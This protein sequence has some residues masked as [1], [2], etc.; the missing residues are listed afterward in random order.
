[1]QGSAGALARPYVEMYPAPLPAHAPAPLSVEGELRRDSGAGAVAVAPS[2]GAR[3]SFLLP[4]Q[5]QLAGQH[6]QYQQ[7]RYIS[8]YRP[9]SAGAY[10]VSS[11]AHSAGAV[12][13]PASVAGRF[14]ALAPP[15]A[16]ATA[17]AAAAVVQPVP[18]PGGSYCHRSRD[19]HTL[20]ACGLPLPGSAQLSAA[21]AVAGGAASAP[22]ARSAA[23]GYRVGQADFSGGAPCFD[24]LA[25]GAVSGGSTSGGTPCCGGGGGSPGGGGGGGD[26][27][28]PLPALHVALTAPVV[29]DVAASLLRAAAA[30]DVSLDTDAGAEQEAARNVTAA[31]HA[32]GVLRF[33][34][35]STSTRTAGCPDH[36]SADAAMSH[37][38]VVAAAVLARR[39]DRDRRRRD[40]AVLSELSG[41]LRLLADRVLA[42]APVLTVP[43]GQE[44]AVPRAGTGITGGGLV[45]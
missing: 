45:V 23:G 7:Q 39:R 38:R 18:P 5:P 9:P 26:L 17:A 30:A 33:D 37:H 32:A 20:A 24:T 6:F 22:S 40:G 36:S 16:A 15:V 2:V 29:A 1:M 10:A 8:G 43:F 13:H 12:L 27:G 25:S 19:A 41:V 44:A 28:I 34:E 3:G 21:S 35:D 42:A 31:E 11:P 4:Q 14:G